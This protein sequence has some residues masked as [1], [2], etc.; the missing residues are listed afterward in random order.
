[1]SNSGDL[2][3]PAQLVVLGPEAD[4]LVG[5]EVGGYVI[6]FALGQGGMGLVYQ[7]RH[8]FLGRRFA[9]KVLRPELAADLTF[10]SN[11]VREAQ[12]LSGL[13]HPHILDI[14]GFGVLDQQRQFMVTEFL[15]GHTLEKELAAHGALPVPRALDLAEQI[16]DGLEAAH[17]IDVIHRDLKPSNVFLARQSGGREVVKLLDFGLAKR[18]PQALNADEATSAVR[19]VIAGTPAYIAPEQALGQGVSKLSDLYSFGVMLFELLKGRPPFAAG[20]DASDPVRALLQLQLFQKAP[21]LGDTFPEALE[22]LVAELLEK[23]SAARPQSVKQVRQRLRRVAFDLQGSEPRQFEGAPSARTLPNLADLEA[24]AL[25]PSRRPLVLGIASLSL[26]VPGLWW[27]TQGSAEKPPAA[28]LSTVQ[29]APSA[30]PAP[31]PA[32]QGPLLLDE[33]EPLT[34]LALQKK[35]SA[36]SPKRSPVIA[37]APAL[38]AAVGGCE[39]TERWRVASRHH[40]QELQQLAA[41]RNDAAVW[42]RFE[43]AE[44]ALSAAINTA[45]TTA[46]CAA[47][48]RRIKQLAKELSP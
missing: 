14:V 38:P 24:R 18:Q 19:S 37:E 31:A 22:Q 17:S 3:S 16:L 2:D 32:P 30:L 20:P 12:T 27:L 45:E 9:I 48:E 25:R 43:D 46:H 13:K 36:T 5:R 40:L 28:L 26:L 15:D 33:L 8:P 23:D 6:E 10:S 4:P 29:A 47:V 21:N 1:M 35:R 11:F 7:A 39:P 44:G 41:N 34:A 42:T